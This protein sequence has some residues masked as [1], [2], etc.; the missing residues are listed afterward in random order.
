MWRRI[1]EIN[2][3]GREVVVAGCLGAVAKEEIIQKYPGVK[4]IDTMGIP[5]LLDSIEQLFGSK[6]NISQEIPQVQYLDRID[7]IVPISTG[8]AG[9]CSYCITKI[10][11]GGIHSYQLK[12][13]IGAVRN[14]TASGRTEI[15]LTSQDTAAFGLDGEDG[16]LGSLLRTITDDVM[17]DYRIRV[18][19]MNPIHAGRRLDH[20]L[21]GYRSE[22]VFKF[23]HIPIQSGS[24][25][26]LKN[27]ERGYSVKDFQGMA[28]RIRDMF[29]YATISTDLIVG[30]PG[31]G[32]KDHD[33]NMEVLKWL[34]PDI[35]NI[36]RFSR[37]PGTKAYRMEGQI[38]GG[39]MKNR[40]RELTIQHSKMQ[41]AIL[42]S[43]LGHHPS[44]LVTEIGKEGTVMAR[45]INYTPIV[46][47][48]G[49]E[50]LGSF[51]DIDT[52]GTGPSYLKGGRDWS[53]SRPGPNKF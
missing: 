31:E 48:G 53:L 9:S 32:R 17:G 35:L 4:V 47:E 3:G 16:D 6:P 26:I 5:S 21:E 30:F 18:G 12:K 1:E 13:I 7:T 28:E 36:T 22:K 49:R 25:R 29:Q 27:M 43:R 23:F 37:R 39:E 52:T 38:V 34:K 40:S 8:C 20:I 24:D 42:E 15:L 45:D 10:A 19:M 46:I 41:T 2:A 11:R 50:L 14:G 44:C 51:I 33:M